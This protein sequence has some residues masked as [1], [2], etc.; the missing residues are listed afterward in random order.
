MEVKILIVAPTVSQYLPA[1]SQNG[2]NGLQLPILCMV[3]YT[4][5]LYSRAHPVRNFQMIYVGVNVSIL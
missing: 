3:Q 4:F 1:E 2:A 5:Q